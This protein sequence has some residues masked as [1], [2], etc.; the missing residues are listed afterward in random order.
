MRFRQMLGSNLDLVCI[1]TKTLNG[2]EVAAATRSGMCHESK[3]GAEDCA[4]E[5]GPTEGHEKPGARCDDPEHESDE[6]S[7]PHA[8]QRASTRG[9]CICFATSNVLD[10]FEVGA[11][12]AQVLNR[13]SVVGKGV[14]DTLGLLVGAYF[15]KESVVSQTIIFF[16]KSIG[17]EFN[18]FL[19]YFT[20]LKGT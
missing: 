7:E 14:N 19:N 1:R 3:D 10:C 17:A 5:N 12:D 4:E 2:R 15:A 18:T 16:L 6:E 9:G 11:D 8:A 13:K 20:N